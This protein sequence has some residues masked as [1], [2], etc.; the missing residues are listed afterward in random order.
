[1]FF[2]DGFTHVD[3]LLIPEHCQEIEYQGLLGGGFNHS[4]FSPLTWGNDPI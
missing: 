4:L 1:M 2:A 3:F